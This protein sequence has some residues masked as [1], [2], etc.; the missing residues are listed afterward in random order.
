MNAAVQPAEW[1]ESPT[2]HVS[3]VEAAQVVTS[4]VVDHTNALTLLEEALRQIATLQAQLAVARSEE[5]ERLA[6]LCEG[7]V[8]DYE[9]RGEHD[10][11]Y[12]ARVC[13]QTI[14][15]VT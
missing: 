5:R 14:R 8:S 3:L 15:R 9:A 11:A 2:G 12:G 7:V 13:V 10:W 1:P 4:L 6:T